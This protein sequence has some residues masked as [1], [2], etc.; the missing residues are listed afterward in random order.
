MIFLNFIGKT[1]LFDFD[2]WWGYIFCQTCCPFTFLP[3]LHFVV[4]HVSPFP[5]ECH[6]VLGPA[7]SLPCSCLDHGS[8]LSVP[9]TQESQAL[10]KEKVCQKNAH[11][12]GPQVAWPATSVTPPARM[13][14]SLPE[15]QTFHL[16]QT[17]DHHPG[18]VRKGGA[19]SDDL[20]R[21]DSHVHSCASEEVFPTALGK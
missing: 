14:E 5:T 4:Y 6:C 20:T 17:L 3:I 1:R 15:L 2:S 21:W 11:S 8:L 13:P 18:T 16:T 19:C 7:S 12:Q 10:C 9:Q